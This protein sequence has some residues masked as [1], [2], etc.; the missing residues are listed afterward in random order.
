MDGSGE[1]GAVAFE[2]RRFWKV[3][4]FTLAVDGIDFVGTRGDEFDAEHAVDVGAEDVVEGSAEVER[5]DDP[6]AFFREVDVHAIGVFLVVFVELDDVGLIA[7]LVANGDESD[8]GEVSPGFAFC[9]LVDGGVEGVE[10][11]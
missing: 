9:G 11:G 7:C 8:S 2:L 5:A 4:F 1:W 10:G 3:I 6:E